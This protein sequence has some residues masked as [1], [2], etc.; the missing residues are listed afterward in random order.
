VV[1]NTWYQVAFLHSNLTQKSS[2]IYGFNTIYWI[3]GRSLL[4]WI[5]T[6][7]FPAFFKVFFS[8]PF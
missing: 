3:F 6:S 5:T 4:S 2:F 7:L 8:F 1:H